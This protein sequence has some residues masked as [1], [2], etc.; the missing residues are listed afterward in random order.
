MNFL[1]DI[2]AS[3]S[4]FFASGV[5]NVGLEKYFI[6]VI[7][8]LLPI[9]AVMILVR[10]VKSYFSETHEKEVWGYL[11]LPN[12][13]RLEL[14]HWENVIGRAKSCDVFLEYPTLSR[15]H[16]AFIRDDKANWTVY[17]LDS[18][19]GILLNGEAVDYSAEVQHGDVLS[20]A[21]VQMVFI[22]V[23]NEEERL[24]ARARKRP[25]KTIKPG[26][27]LLC[28]TEFQ[29]LL[30]AELMMSPN[31]ENYLPVLI[32]FAGLCALM[33]IYYLFM[34]TLGRTGVEVESIAFFLSTIGLAVVASSTPDDLYKQL[35]IT[36]AGLLIFLAIGWFLRD[37][38]RV[39]K[40][41]W[42]IAAIGIAMLAINVVLAK[43]TFGARNWL[44][45]GGISIQPSEIVKIC[46]VF[47]GAA[48][49][50]R[51]FAK[52]NIFMFVA[53][54]L[55]CVGALALI[56]D[57]G[58]AAIFFV[59]YLV[60]AFMRSGDIATVFLSVGGAGLA[61]FLAITVKPYIKSRF[62][63]WGKAWEYMN[64]GGYQQTRTMAALASGGLLGV[65]AGN[66]WLKNVFAANTDMVFGMVAEELGL[67]IA[68][69]TTVAIV[70]IAIFA[71]RS[72]E[73]S[74]SSFY[75]IGACAAVSI[76]L[77]QTMLNVFGSLDILPFTGVTF[78]FVS[79]GG[80]SLLSCWGLLAFVKA[81]DTRQN[82]SFAIKLPKNYRK[83]AYEDKRMVEQT[84]EET[85]N[86][87]EYG[88]EYW[89]GADEI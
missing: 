38:D 62:A 52:R 57:F 71:I 73:N 40:M 72:A 43:T 20:L 65:G 34:R 78:P 32:S 51:L 19:G 81:A 59:C 75:V 44:S 23:S 21:G 53:Y 18:K 10:C 5:A 48:T 69:S 12:G 60:I 56:S 76:L 63:T 30:A 7:R 79:K 80:T 70:I 67:I 9:L 1:N 45:I 84:E 61:G 68:I 17:D 88:E 42:P 82:A 47:C 4:E 74:R 39:K 28:I 64:D 41:R 15:S 22:A 26:L 85:E 25:G 11:S 35:L 77:F 46:F 49:L 33:W 13:S 2:F 50:D 29:F 27:T 24:Q 54:S 55:V 66:G 8:I 89:E 6:M 37:L 36:A 83:F 16:A 87:Y 31:I 86:G 3:V 14:N 58:T